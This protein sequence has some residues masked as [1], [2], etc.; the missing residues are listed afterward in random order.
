MATHNKKYKMSFGTGGLF[1]NESAELARLYLSMP[2]P[3]WEDALNLGLKEGLTSLPKSESN[4]RTLREIKNR[5][6]SLTEEEIKYFCEDA[7]R[8]EQASLLWLA[9]CRTYRI[10]REFAVE[11]IREQYLSYQ[12]DLPLDSFDRLYEAKAEWDDDLAALT[13]TTFLKVRQVLFRLMREASII[14]E[15]RKILSSYLSPALR[16]LIINNNPADLAV[17]PGIPLEGDIS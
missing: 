5:L 7:D 12:L 10:I 8:Q 14:S 16:N 13:E 9:A 15:D 11:V 4:R 17:F 1:I 3:N 6:S 2:S